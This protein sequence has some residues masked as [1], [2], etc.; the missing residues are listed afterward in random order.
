MHIILT[1]IR[2]STSEQVHQHGHCKRHIRD[3]MTTTRIDNRSMCKQLS[4]L[5]NCKESRRVGSSLILGKSPLTLL[6]P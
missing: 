2:V 6:S 3:I 5:Y 4:V 1:V